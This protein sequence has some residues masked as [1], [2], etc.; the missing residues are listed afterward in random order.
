MYRIFVHIIE[1]II[2]I[3]L[4]L[5]FLAS[6]GL[7]LV[8]VR[9]PQA[10]SE[11]VSMLI[12]KPTVTPFQL[13][14]IGVLGDSQSDEY[15]ADDNR[16]ENYPSTTRNWVEILA[17][18]RNIP[19][20][21][22]DTYDEPRRSGFAYNWARSGATARSMIASGQHIGLAEQVKKGE[23][24]VVIIS[25]GANDYAPYITAD[26]Y[27]AIYNGELT[28]AQLIAKR[29][30]IVANIKTAIDTIQTAGNPK[31][32]LVQIPDWGNN[33]GVHMVFPLPENRQRVTNVITAANN[34][35]KALAEQYKIATI[36]PNRFYTDIIKKQQAGK[37]QVDS[38][39]M[40]RLL[41]TND[42][43]NLFLSDGIH[44][45]T[46]LNGL[47]A[48]RIIE[49]LNTQYGTSIKP[50]SE[51]EIVKIAGL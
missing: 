35:L 15:R 42:P 5:W 32:L 50:L 40:E 38:V 12:P 20:G 22:W 27:E 10:V 11:L 39:S 1:P 9:N 43:K 51:K 37:M 41:L 13:K 47:F 45:G 30:D 23:V 49:T 46:V 48:N 8:T 36:D 21:K 17:Q 19:F 25:I 18:H 6:I 26:G 24:N 31:I 4:V 29:N 34:D 2:I 3:F 28:P 44:P 7:A 16:G 14:G 33:L